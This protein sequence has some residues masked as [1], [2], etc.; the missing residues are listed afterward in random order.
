MPLERYLRRWKQKGDITDVPKLSNDPA[1]NPTLYNIKSA[2]YS[3]TYY[4]A[5]SM[6]R[7]KNASI[8]YSLPDHLLKKVKMEGCRI[9]MQG[10]NL[11]TITNYKGWDP[12][13]QSG[14]YPLLRIMTAGIELKF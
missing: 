13:N 7:L 1:S 12:E 3:N 6:V 8:S 9:Y 14:N 4:T 2:A 5:I 10:Q 11:L